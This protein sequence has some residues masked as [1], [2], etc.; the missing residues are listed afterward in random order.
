M[1]HINK[2]SI[3]LS[4]EHASLIKDVVAAGEFA[5][6]SEVIGEALREWQERRDDHGYTIA[7][8]RRLIQE[9]IDSGPALDG[10]TVMAN[11]RERIRAKAEE[12]LRAKAEG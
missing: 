7:E 4:P 6:P 3:K 5:S 12:R 10:P 1:G 9:G 11:L 8:L 2:H